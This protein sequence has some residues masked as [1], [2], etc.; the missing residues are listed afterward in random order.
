LSET[1][2]I[3]ASDE[4]WNRDAVAFGD[5]LARDVACGDIQLP[6]F[7][8]VVLRV[9]HLLA[10]ER[11]DLHDIA[12]AITLDPELAMLV[13]RIAN[14][15]AFN[16]GGVQAKD[17]RMAVQRVGTRIVRA[18][19]LSLVV[20]M[21]RS[22]EELRGLRD[23]LGA[24]WRRGITVGS[25]AKALAQ[26]TGVAAADAGL[27]A[28]LLH[29]VGRL[30]VLARMHEIP[31]LFEQEGVPEKLLD[32]WSDTVTDVLLLK[33]EVPR[34]FCEAISQF[35]RRWQAD[36]APRPAPG[37][38]DVLVV[39]QLLADLMPPSRADYLDQ[40]QLAQVCL[41][42]EPD[43]ARLGLTRE[44]CSDAIHSALAEVQQLR[45]L[46]GA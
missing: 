35:Q 39:A 8:P 38:G 20:Q 26:R 3:S 5:M 13:L 1:T 18:A 32:R 30:Y 37:L 15:S 12:Q 6:G 36:A 40:V 10:D 42:H 4:T 16:P 46:L 11:A 27:L 2:N 25:V 44:A 43:L 9:H 45:A 21:L 7:P 17:M 23:R 41:L 33:W 31:H 29:V 34:E 24:V 28:G 14:A 22:A 19:T